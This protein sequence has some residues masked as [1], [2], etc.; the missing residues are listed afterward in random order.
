MVLL[1]KNQLIKNYIASSELTHS[2]NISDRKKQWYELIVSPSCPEES[3][4]TADVVLILE[5]TFSISDIAEVFRMHAW[6]PILI[7]SARAHDIYTVEAKKVYIHRSVHNRMVKSVVRC[8]QWN[9]N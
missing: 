6:T 4:C 8:V 7:Y 2:I 3:C 1:M 5:L 9:R